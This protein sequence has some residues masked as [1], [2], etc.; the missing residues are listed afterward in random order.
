[1]L[2]RTRAGGGSRGVYRHPRRNGALPFDR[3]QRDDA[4]M[5]VIEKSCGGDQ[6]Q[7]HAC[8]GHPVYEEPP[9]PWLSGDL[10][11]QTFPGSLA[12]IESLAG[13]PAGIVQPAAP[14]Q[15]LIYSFVGHT[16]HPLK[17]TFFSIE[18]SPSATAI[19]MCLP[20]SPAA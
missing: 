2:R 7:Q 4:V 19:S 8:C 1:M 5:P 20:Q 17:T 12:V 15:E 18:F 10:V 6:C 3:P 11:H 9:P 16:V 14:G 13:N